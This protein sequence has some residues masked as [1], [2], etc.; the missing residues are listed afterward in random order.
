MLRACIL[1]LLV[2]LVPSVSAQTF[3]TREQAWIVSHPRVYYTVE[4]FWPQESVRNG[5]HTGLSREVLNEVTRR[6]GIQ[7]IY[8]TPGQESLHRPM[9]ISALTGSLLTD[10]QRQRWLL[11]FSWLSTMPII[12]AAKDQVQVRTLA[13]LQGKRIAIATD[14]E[15]APWIKRHY[16]AI[17]VVLK[18]DVRSALQ[19]VAEGENVA[20]I[21]YGLVILPVLQH[22]YT[23]QL[24]VVAQI[25]EM[26]TS[27]NMGIDPAYPELRDIL[28]Q[29]M[30]DITPHDAERLFSHW[31]SIMDVWTPTLQYAIWQYRYPLMIIGILLLMLIIAVQFALRS[32]QRAIRSNE[33]KSK[34]L[35]VMSHEV[36]TPMNAIIASLELLQHSNNSSIKRQQYIDLA[37]SCSQDLLDL[38]NNVLDNEKLIQKNIALNYEPVAVGILLEAV[39]DSHRPAAQKKGCTLTLED[40]RY[41]PAEL[42]FTDA[43]RLRQIVN[44]LLSNAI[45]FTHNGTVL[46]RLEYHEEKMCI[47]VQDSGIGIDPALKNRL[48]QAWQQGEHHSGGSGLGLY[49]CRSLVTQM[50]GT[51]EIS[52]HVGRGTQVRILLP[53]QTLST[54]DTQEEPQQLTL[55]DFQKKCSVLLVEDHFANRQLIAEQLTRL[56]CHFE[57]AE[58]GERAIQLFEDE[59]YYDVILLD[60]GLPG[61][62]GYAVAKQIR[63]LEQLQQRERTP[64]IAI[65]ALHTPLHRA[66][67]Q[68][69]GMDG[70]MSKPIRINDLADELK[71]WCHFVALQ[72]SD[73]EFPVSVS[74]QIWIALQQ[75][76]DA[77][78]TAVRQAQ[79]RHMVHHIHRI[80][81]VAQMYHLHE[82]AH[83]S[84]ALESDLRAGLPPDEWALAHWHCQLKILCYSP[85]SKKD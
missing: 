25:P 85:G 74:E 63:Q 77:F 27:V 46:L 68:E 29:V 75:D 48:M 43:N 64:I 7:F 31:I 23:N 44:N 82:L 14:S 52:S 37:Y 57:I 8:V 2:S 1:L 53:L 66:S 67:C 40:V 15:F 69:S 84:E 3:T 55:P 30:A 41:N 13:Q 71:K 10:V 78:L 59:N 33:H 73:V 62:D 51:I 60:C 20:A 18:P 58:D 38:L 56:G 81:G 61:M 47:T 32:R 79:T 5:K 80:K 12:V 54:A 65:S 28:N 24:G 83:F 50:H 22:H 42:V 45:K 36:R 49:I 9:M 21:A 6:T 76:A 16:P 19:S 39:T 17:D 72:K 35:A 70:V 11:T 34:F 4:N 26:V